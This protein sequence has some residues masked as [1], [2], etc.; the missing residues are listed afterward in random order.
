MKLI[1]SLHSRWFSGLS[2]AGMRRFVRKSMPLLG[3]P[4]VVAL[5]ML[6]MCIAFYFSAVRPLQQRIDAVKLSVLLAGTEGTDGRTAPRSP[7][8]QLEEF[9]RFF[10][11][12]RNSPKWLGRMAEVA[13]QCGLSLNHGEYA[14][15]EDKVGRLSRYRISLPVEGQYLQIRKFLALLATEMPMMALENVQFERKDIATSAVQAK[16]RLVLYFGREPQS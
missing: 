3:I 2:I 11:G 1:L 15:I 13:A 12:E 6:I 8:A 7:A 16:I 9:Y 4:G 14:V 5:G 10:P